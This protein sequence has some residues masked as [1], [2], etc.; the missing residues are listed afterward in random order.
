MLEDAWVK[1]ASARADPN[2]V[3]AAAAPGGRIPALFRLKLVTR[4]RTGVMR[5]GA[6][7][8]RNRGAGG[9]G[10]EGASVFSSRARARV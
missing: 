6:H 1:R 10:A 7:S 3:R 5:R 4:A 2:N 8:A 9:G